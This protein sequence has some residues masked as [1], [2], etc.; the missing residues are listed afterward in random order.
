MFENVISNE[1]LSVRRANHLKWC[2]NRAFE[3]LE[4]G[5]IPGAFQ[6]FVSDIS[7]DNTT[8]SMIEIVQ[9]LSMPLMLM[10]ELNTVSKMR[11]HIEGF[12]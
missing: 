11:A 6:S 3:L 9:N 1:D 8:S 4:R 2:K 12:N 5:D 7:K 10:G